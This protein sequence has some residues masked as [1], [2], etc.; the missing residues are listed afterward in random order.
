VTAKKASG[1][2]KAA[3]DESRMREAWNASAALTGLPEQV[4]APAT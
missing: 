4:Q 1:F 2:V 3:R